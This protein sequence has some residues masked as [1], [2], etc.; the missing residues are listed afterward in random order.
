M[1]ASTR[2]RCTIPPADRWSRVQSTLPPI[3]RG[4]NMG[5][6]SKPV[7]LLLTV[8]SQAL[9]CN[10]PLTTTKFWNCWLPTKPTQVFKARWML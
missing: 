8:Q 5:A 10:H 2:R 4:P 1:R 6:P 7:R 3:M 9:P